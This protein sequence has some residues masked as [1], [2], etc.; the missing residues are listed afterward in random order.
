MSAKDV[1][2]S[3]TLPTSDYYT[4]VKMSN[5]AVVGVFRQHVFARRSTRRYAPP[6]P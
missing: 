1:P 3:I 4:I 5:H 2:P 6:H